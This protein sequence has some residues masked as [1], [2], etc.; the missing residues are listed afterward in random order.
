VP[1]ISGPDPKRLWT[2]AA[3]AGIVTGLDHDAERR[4]TMRTMHPFS[5]TFAP[6]GVPSR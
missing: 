4:A 6:F 3:G 5:A 2:T 1:T